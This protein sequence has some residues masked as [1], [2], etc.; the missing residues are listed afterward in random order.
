MKQTL[1][2][3]IIR[4]ICDENISHIF[5]VPGKNIVPF[6]MAID[7]FTPVMSGI[8]CASELGA[9]F[10]ADGYARATQKFGVVITISGP[11]FNNIYGALVNAS[12]DQSKLLIICGAPSSILTGKNIFQDTSIYK[13]D[14]SVIAANLCSYSCNLT[15]LDFQHQLKNTF[16]YLENYNQPAFLQIPVNIQAQ[17]GQFEIDSKKVNQKIL[18]QHALNRLEH[19][20]ATNA[21]FMIVTGNRAMEAASSIRAFCERYHIPVASTLCSKGIISEKAEY[22]LGIFGFG[23]SPRVYK[24]INSDDLQYIITLGL[25]FSERNTTKW[26]VFKKKHTIHL[27]NI[28]SEN[29]RDHSGSLEIYLTDISL[30]FEKLLNKSAMATSLS[31][32]INIRKEFILKIKQA[33][34]YHIDICHINK[35]PLYID[36]VL[37]SINAEFY[38]NANVVVD[39]GTHRLY[40]AHIW[41]M[42]DHES[43]FTSINN[44]HMGWAIAAS[45]GIKIANPH[46]D[47]L[48]I[49][50][51][52]CMLMNGTEIQTA[53]K[54]NIK[55]LFVVLNNNAHGAMVSS[56]LS[57]NSYLIPDHD[58]SLFANAFGIKSMTVRNL[59]DLEIGFQNFRNSTSSLLLDIKCAYDETIRLN[60]YYEN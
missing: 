52:G 15:H 20:F 13:F 17:E 8:I 3:T 43:Y 1:A 29:S 7:D 46:K 54:Y 27:D 18:N 42:H 37:K 36:Q 14:C 6:L 38:T 49:T 35:N 33:M 44:G 47:C 10:M 21:G 34:P 12:Y 40:C 5:L 39:S 2:H 16:F 24:L 58:W 28:I 59:I 30:L 56:K 50:G 19:I 9:G 55:V 11:G 22:Y 53:A 32:S 31:N 45:I 41:Q 57:K 51:D 25:D 26:N 23:M 60:Q 4:R 48:C